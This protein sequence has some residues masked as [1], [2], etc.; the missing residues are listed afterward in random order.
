MTRSAVISIDAMGGDNGPAAIVAGLARALS[1]DPG[2]R[3]LV[4]GDGAEL[5]RLIRRRG[6]LAAACDIR[7]TRDIVLMTDKPSRAVRERRDSSMGHALAAVARGEAGVA[8]S[9]G[10]TGAL[11][12]MAVLGLR[13]APGVDRPAIAVQW[14]STAPHGFTTVLDMGAD[15]RADPRNLL[16]YAVMGA[17]YARLSFGLARP[18]VGVLNVGRE[19]GKG[20]E[21]LRAAAALIAALAARPDARIESVGFVEGNDIPGDRVDVVVTDGF[22]G[23]VALKAAEGTAGFI[24]ATLKTAFTH[25]LLSRL[26]YLFALTSLR[27][28]AKRIDPRRVN[29]GV[30][31][32][33]NGPVVKSHGSADAVGFAAAVRLAALMAQADFTARVAAAL[34][35]SAV[36]VPLAGAVPDL[37]LPGDEAAAR[38]EG[39]TGT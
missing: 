20:P 37:M 27:R 21:E 4:H 17:E 10:N 13:K 39:E 23:N 26:G 34:D 28:F 12:A 19:P 25:S 16:Q 11:L 31:L 35:R 36:P 30:F 14:P 38:R 7:P 1:A 24:R 5:A 8:I 32:G 33:L 6:A 18:R 3:F 29:G 2:L 15:V 9:T 22:T